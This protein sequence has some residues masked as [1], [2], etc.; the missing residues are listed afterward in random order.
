MSAFYGA[1]PTILFDDLEA[2][3]LAL[4]TTACIGSLRLR[5]EKNLYEG[6][7]FT[8]SMDGETSRV[9]NSLACLL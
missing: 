2:L 5:I 1:F 7:G 6:V 4:R 3:A 8:C 9:R